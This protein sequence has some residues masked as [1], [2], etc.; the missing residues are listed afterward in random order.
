MENSIFQ[1]MVKKAHLLPY[2]TSPR[3]AV[4]FLL[5]LLETTGNACLATRDIMSGLFGGFKRHH[6]AILWLKTQKNQRIPFFSKFLQFRGLKLKYTSVFC[7][8]HL[9]WDPYEQEKLLPA[10]YTFK[11]FLARAPQSQVGYFSY[12]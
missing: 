4:F 8:P 6:L 10:N 12:K 9:I 1:K 5:F 3:S 11:K 7:L 2:L